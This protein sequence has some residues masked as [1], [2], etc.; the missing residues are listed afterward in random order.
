MSER[1]LTNQWAPWQRLIDSIGPDDR[2]QLFTAR[3]RARGELSDLDE[4][5]L[6]AIASHGRSVAGSLDEG[7]RLTV[8][9][10][11]E[12]ERHSRLAADMRHETELH[13]RRQRWAITPRRR[14]QARA[15]AAERAERAEEHRRRAAQSHE[16]L[17]ELGN[18]GRHLYPWFERHQGALGR[19]PA[20]EPTV[21][22]AQSAV[23][24]L[25][26]A[27]G[28]ASLTAA[29]LTTDRAIDLGELQELVKG[30]G[31]VRQRLL[32][33]VAAELYGREQG[34]S[35]SELLAEL[36]GEDLDHV[37]L[38]RSPWSSG[39]GS[40]APDRPTIS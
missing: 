34:V 14:R 1:R 37:C 9:L 10:T 39:A 15:N 8:T 5:Q 25:L 12:R 22:A 31:E 7:A 17:R 2:T 33:A 36:D 27:P 28:I 40:C 4:E 35:L 18:S 6:E 26:G 24:H 30:G 23:Y 3:D 11:E 29:C 32:F 16:Q 19:G 21:D 20:A 38:K 13:L